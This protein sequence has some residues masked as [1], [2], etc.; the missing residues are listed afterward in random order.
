M[1]DTNCEV[2]GSN[3]YI[4]PGLHFPGLCNPNPKFVFPQVYGPPRLY[5]PQVYVTLIL[6]P[7][8]YFPRS[9]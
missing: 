2:D 3:V 8:A 5:S 9:T 4:P 1:C 7:D 6:T